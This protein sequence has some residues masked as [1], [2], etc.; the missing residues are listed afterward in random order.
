[1]PQN[2]SPNAPPGAAEGKWVKREVLEHVKRKAKA[3]L[4]ELEND[5]MAVILAMEDDT[6][7]QDTANTANTAHHPEPID[8]VEDEPRG[9]TNERIKYQDTA[10]TANTEPGDGIN[11]RINRVN[12]DGGKTPTSQDTPRYPQIPPDTPRYSQI[13]PDTPTSPDTWERGLGDRDAGGGGGSGDAVLRGEGG[14]SCVTSSSITSSVT[15]LAGLFCTS[16]TS[17]VT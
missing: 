6:Y 5:L 10:N 11:E 4:A 8:C 13:P 9:S 17:S 12:N 15:V 16:V 2:L 1:M 7:H 3:D 14:A